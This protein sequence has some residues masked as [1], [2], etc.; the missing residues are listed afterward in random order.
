MAQGEATVLIITL[1]MMFLLGGLIIW[2]PT[3]V[4]NLQVKIYK[5]LLGIE[6]KYSKRTEQ[7]MRFIGVI[8]ICLIL[9]GGYHQFYK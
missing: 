7:I 6:M 9:I 4:L 1:G 5:K 3:M 8:L 2:K